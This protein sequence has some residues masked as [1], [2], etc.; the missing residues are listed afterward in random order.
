VTGLF[1]FEAISVATTFTSFRT[2]S[3]HVTW[4]FAF[5]ASLFSTASIA[6]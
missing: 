3:G 1:A 5:E 6:T 2:F 4:F